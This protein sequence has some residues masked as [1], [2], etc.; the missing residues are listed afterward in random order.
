MNIL[1]TGGCGFLGRNLIGQLLRKPG[2]SVCVVD[3]L[4]VGS[5]ADLAEIC[6]V[7]RARQPAWG[8]GSVV[9]L[10]VGDITNA[11]FMLD[12]AEGA[13]AIVHL[14]ANSGVALSVEN[15]RADC[16]ANIIGTL[17]ALE[18]ARANGVRRFVFASSGAPIGECLP[19]IHEEMAPHPVSPYGASKLAGEAYCSAYSRT[20][21]IDTVALRFGNV[22]GPLSSHKSSVVAR[23]IRH[24]L[25]GAP[26]EI[27]GSGDQTRDFI[28]VGDLVNA[29]LAALVA[30][31]VGG[32]V[33]QIATN[34]ET[35]IN[36]LTE[37]LLA[38]FAEVGIRGV[39]VVRHGPRL[40]D[41]MRNFSDTSKAGRMLG[42]QPATSLDEG[43]RQTVAWFLG[44]NKHKALAA[45]SA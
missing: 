42:W 40:G 8:R 6:R 29:V 21:G 41:V 26:L 2:V 35:S 25:D 16:L 24:A 27:F 30:P 15:P 12:A 5:E 33:F 44:S 22:Y 38:V 36:E 1:V 18:A 20:F 13:D 34:R 19:P 39:E 4:S 37:H 28:F 23:M 45:L 7:E 43:V 31:E 32:H 14:A 17:N 10:M 11:E 9:T 3:N